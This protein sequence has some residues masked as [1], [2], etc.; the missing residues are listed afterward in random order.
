MNDQHHGHDAPPASAGAS[1]SRGMSPLAWIALSAAVLLAVWPMIMRSPMMPPPGNLPEARTDLGYPEWR[2]RVVGADDRRG[3]MAPEL[4]VDEWVNDAV[5]LE[6]RVVVIDFW[7]TWCPPCV[8]SIPHLNELA[9]TFGDRAA[10]VAISSEDRGSFDVGLQG[11][12]RPLSGFAYGLALDP[13]MRTG[14]AMNVT[15]IPHLV[16]MSRDGIVRWQGN[17]KR[18]DADTLA[19]II[20]ADARVAGG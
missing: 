4:V 19:A 14:R 17:P 13:A 18:L 1:T 3:S 8:A 12:G 15:S 11:V 6:D 9:E 2:G 20:D 7:A 5:D 16:V 10:F